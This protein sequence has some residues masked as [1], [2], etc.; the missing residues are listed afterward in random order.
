MI[1]GKSKYWGKL[2]VDVSLLLP[3][4][5]LTPLSWPHIHGTADI[6]TA[7]ENS[8]KLKVSNEDSS[9]SLNTFTLTAFDWQIQRGFSV[10]SITTQDCSKFGLSDKYLKCHAFVSA[11]TLKTLIKLCWQ[12]CDEISGSGKCELALDLLWFEHK[13][14]ALCV[15][16]GRGSK[17]AV[18]F[19]W[20]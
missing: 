9:I 1:P 20:L 12:S 11:F 13:A 4:V 15:G 19:L 2:E 3:S 18:S 14:T 7:Q 8:R 17:T 6:S 10:T 5:S 16:Q